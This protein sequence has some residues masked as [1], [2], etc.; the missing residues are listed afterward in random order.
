L[1][2]L[3]A[4][5]LVFSF[6]FSSCNLF[7]NSNENVII[8]VGQT[9]ISE[10]KLKNDIKRITFEMGITDQDARLGIQTLINKAIDEYLIMEYGK[11]RNITISEAELESAINEI[12]KDYPEEVFQSMLLERYIDL[13]GWKTWLRQELL[14]K[15][16]VTEALAA[17]PPITYQ[18]IKAYYE[19]HQ[20]EFKHSLK[21]ELMQIVTNTREEAKDLVKQLAEGADMSELAKQHSIAPEAE[22]GGYLGWVEK[23]TLDVSMDKVIFSL[24]LGKI[25]TIVETPYGYHIFRVMSSQQEGY[26]SLPDSME[27]I[28]SKLLSEKKDGFYREWLKTLKSQYPVVIKKEITDQWSLEE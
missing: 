16:I 24:P 3:T 15:K 2:K 7:D 4:I 8:T 1:K 10:D 20:E 6:A 18:E 9:E 26:T 17:I 5:L 11:E 27:S 14:A 19:S 25:S 13:K 22:A 28:E 12:K 21:V 23:G